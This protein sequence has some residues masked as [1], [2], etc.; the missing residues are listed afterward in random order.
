MLDLA[1]GI[2]DHRLDW[3]PHHPSHAFPQK[4]NKEASVKATTLGEK[5]LTVLPT[6]MTRCKAGYR[7]L[8]KGLDEALAPRLLL[9]KGEREA[10]CL[11]GRASDK[12]PQCG[13][14]KPSDDFT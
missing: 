2:V 4:L 3:N 1:E 7:I 10:L 12:P 14:G 5:D 8:V 9:F 6:V 11:S 13:A